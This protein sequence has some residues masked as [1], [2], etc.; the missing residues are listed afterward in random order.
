MNRRNFFK[1]TGK[2]IAGL[3]LLIAGKSGLKPQEGPIEVGVDLAIDRNDPMGGYLVP[4]EYQKQIIEAIQRQDQGII[5]GA[6]SSI[7]IK[8]IGDIDDM[9]A[10]VRNEF[11]TAIDA[12]LDH[13]WLTGDGTGKPLGILNNASLLVKNHSHLKG[14]KHYEQT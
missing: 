12:E 10:F 4:L 7:D 9:E 13:Q 14:Q 1:L 8:A 6:R 2:M 11:G 5:M 3:A